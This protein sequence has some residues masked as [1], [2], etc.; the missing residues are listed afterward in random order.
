MDWFD[1]C[2]VSAYSTCTADETCR[3][4]VCSLA[5]MNMIIS[6]AL[7][8]I[9]EVVGQEQVK[10]IQTIGTYRSSQPNKQVL[11]FDASTHRVYSAW[12]THLPAPWHQTAQTPSAATSAISDRCKTPS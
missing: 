8:R 6:Q 10:Q 11:V 7:G 9:G 2:I 5:E 4:A 3:H 12:L 1:A